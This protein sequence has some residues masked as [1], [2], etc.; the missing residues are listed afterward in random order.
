MHTATLESDTAFRLRELHSL[1]YEEFDRRAH[2]SAVRLL[3]QIAKESRGV[4]PLQDVPTA[5]V[6]GRL[7]YWRQMYDR[8]RSG[9]FKNMERAMELLEYMR[10]EDSK[11]A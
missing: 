10:L 1:F 6:E 5:T 11:R 3:K 2:D 9:P 4:P 8:A 7:G